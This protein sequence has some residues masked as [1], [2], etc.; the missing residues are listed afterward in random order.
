MK[1]AMQS[2]VAEAPRS[3]HVNGVF[4]YEQFYQGELEKKHQDK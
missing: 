1:T 3:A 4:N 2:K